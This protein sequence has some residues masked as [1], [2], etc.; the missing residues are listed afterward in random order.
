MCNKDN[1]NKD[2]QLE[3]LLR[4][5]RFEM[6]S[7]ERWLEFDYAFEN[8]RLSAIKESRIGRMFTSLGSILN[9]KRIVCSVGFCLLFLIIS[10]ASARH[11]KNLS[12]MEMAREVSK[13]YVQ[14]ASDGMLVSDD[15]INIQA[16]ICNISYPN[17]G[18]EYVQDM[19]T[20]QNNSSLPVRMW[21]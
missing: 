3:K 2:K 14:F 6:P 13:K 10:I 19:L 1:N 20:M 17:D 4:I 8:K 11:Q 12:N 7:Q 21:N 5:K 16:G 15:D 9:F 18:I